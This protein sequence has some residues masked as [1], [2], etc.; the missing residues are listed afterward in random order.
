M[1][2]GGWIVSRRL[3][4]F[5]DNF[6]AIGIDWNYI[7]IDSD[8][9]RW[10]KEVLM[11]F[12][13][14][15]KQT[16]N[17][18]NFFELEIIRLENFDQRKAI[19]ATRIYIILF[20]ILLTIL[21]IYLAFQG[22]TRTVT[23]SNP[24]QSDF[25]TLFKEYPN[26]L[27]CPC[28]QI[29]IPYEIFL[30]IIIDYHPICSS[31]FVSVDWI[32]LLFN[33]NISYFYPLDFRSSSLGQFQ[34]LSS[35]CSLSKQYLDEHIHDLLSDSF[36]SPI[37][38]SSQLLDH[39][40]QSQSSF[41]RA[42][43]ANAFLQL[44]QLIRSAT[45]VDVLQNAAQTARISRSWVIYDG[46]ITTTEYSTH[47]SDRNGTI[48]GCDFES[49]CSSSFSG[50]FNLSAYETVPV[51]DYTSSQS[52]ITE[53]PGFVVGCYAL[54]SLLQSSLE[55]LYDLQ[56][57][58]IILNFFP[59]IN[60]NN[61]TYL[62]RN[63]TKYSI[64]T[65]VNVFVENLFIENWT[66][67]S[68]FENYYNM[69]APLLCTY[70]F[71]QYNNI[72]YIITQ[73]LGLY[74]G[75]VLVLRFIIPQILLKFNQRVRHEST[76]ITQ[77]RL[78]DHLKQ[79]NLFKKFD[80]TRNDPYELRTSRIATRFFSIVFLVTMCILVIYALV[81]VRTQSF[82][83][84]QPSQSTF[85][86]LYMKYSSEVK[87]ACK[88]SF[89]S[90]ESFLSLSPEYHPVCSSL[91]VSSAWLASLSP[92]NWLD[93]FFNFEDFRVTGI[94]IF[95]AIK[96]LC[97]YAEIIIRNSWQNF[98]QS[99]YVTEFALSKS[100]MIEQIQ[101][102]ISQFQSGT[103]AD[104]KQNLDTIRLHT[105]NTL[106]TSMLNGGPGSYKLLNTTDTYIDFQYFSADW[107]E[108]SCALTD[109]CIVPTVPG[110]FSGCFAIRSAF[111]SSLECFYNE[112]C[113]S[114]I[115][116]MIRSNRSISVI[117][118]N[119]SQT[120]YSPNS[121]IE[122]IFNELMLEKWGEKIEY[123]R[124]YEVC[125]PISCTYTTI[126]HNDLTYIV[127]FLLGLFGGV[128]I[129]LKIL[130]LFLVEWI[131]NRS[132]S[133]LN[134]TNLNEQNFLERFSQL[135]NKLK[136]KIRT[137]NI[138]ESELS[139][140]N[141]QHR[142]Q[143]I[144]TTRIYFLL[145]L[146][147]VIIL[148]TFTS[149]SVLT[150][151]ITIDYPTQSMFDNLRLNSRISSTLECF[152]QQIG[153]SYKSFISI[154]PHF[155]QLCSSDFT[156]INSNWTRVLYSYG[157]DDEHSYDDYRLFA[158]PQFR[159][160]S[161]LCSVSKTT[162][163]N[164]L[165]QFHSKTLINKQIQSYDVIQSQSESAI[166]R[167]RS[168][169]CKTFVWT[170]DF[171][172]EMNQGNGIVSLIFSNWYFQTLKKEDK[173]YLWTKP[174]SYE[175]QNNCSCGISSMCSS[176]AKIENTS[177]PGLRIGCS[178]IDSF[179]QSTLEC[180]Y[181]ISCINLLKSF[182]FVQDVLISPLN[183]NLSSSNETVQDLIDR[184]LIDEWKY[185]ISYENYYRTC[186]PRSCR[187]TIEERVDALDILTRLIGFYGGLT[188]A[189]KMITPLLMNILQHFFQR[190]QNRSSTQIQ[191]VL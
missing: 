70:T 116:T 191:P 76:E 174:R 68:S 94:V 29:T 119:Q 54:E 120:R 173:A 127:T 145:L 130:V 96:I 148:I 99:L 52:L 56:C 163:T 66:I 53:V 113:L 4:S 126:K 72:L 13:R 185:N 169:L 175:D 162:V 117:S 176:S 32:N 95:Q 152:C 139:W 159:T 63:E 90:Y 112:T 111:H 154:E 135:I 143:E 187:Y 189:L 41:I 131:R 8:V 51:G 40:S 3:S 55:C 158:L 183:T 168:S 114:A 125:A 88:Q 24:L 171:I 97:S 47:F 137:H 190:F 138:F 144:Q 67:N 150:K 19:I 16:I 5:S 77:I 106:S 11:N 74:G 101:G 26:S 84:L 136:I 6:F 36:L 91:F 164:N 134:P 75:L 147:H 146:F 81:S 28:Q 58:N 170:F 121:S 12:V 104:F 60:I 57:I 18:L 14:R 49:T 43:S 172:R 129:S 142:Q 161:L 100:E 25:T 86:N 85:E 124:Y 105:I 109:D 59:H 23:L 78:I 20:S 179:L 178:I 151:S 33:Y 141:E 128:S 155:H 177:I 123:N 122:T 39:Q 149:F 156:N 82:T 184:L 45:S 73:I 50:F 110:L 80:A 7:E 107:G 44:L 153:I 160:L 166:R 10:M 22:E 1:R 133:N 180:F 61:I 188:I 48:C 102:I 21:V 186:S 65:L 62:N 157:I 9:N 115:E 108:C 38:L 69:C 71:I 46:L 64:D 27:T 93:T 83:I 89:I 140:L 92:A 103:I 17:E 30:D 98:K 35:L 165:I 34:I 118:L 42:S 2:D 15:I 167:F 87:C 182:Y 79:F 37:A 181:N 132:R 31:I